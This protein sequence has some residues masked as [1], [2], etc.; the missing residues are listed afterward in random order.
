MRQFIK[1]KKGVHW[2][3][4]EV[5]GKDRSRTKACIAP[6]SHENEKSKDK[7]TSKCDSYV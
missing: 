2:K 4:N 5:K 7:S 3:G 6:E 1:E